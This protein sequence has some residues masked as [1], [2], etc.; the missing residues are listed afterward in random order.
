MHHRSVGF[1]EELETTEKEPAAA[2]F[3]LLSQ[4]LLSGINEIR[5]ISGCI[6]C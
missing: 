4:N 6:T 3:E 2:C 1:Y 5:N